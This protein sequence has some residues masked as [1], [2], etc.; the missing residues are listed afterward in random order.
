MLTILAGAFKRIVLVG[1][2]HDART[3]KVLA[4]RLPPD[5]MDYL[6]LTAPGTLN[7]L[8]QMAAELEERQ[9]RPADRSRERHF[10]LPLPGGRLHLQPRRSLQQDSQQGG[11]RADRAMAQSFALPQNIVQPFSFSTVV[12]AHTHQAGT[13]H[14]DFGTLCNKGGSM[15]PTKGYQSVA[16]IRS[17]RPPVIGWSVIIRQDGVTDHSESRF[18]PLL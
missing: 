18:I 15:C 13:V 8:E 1:C 11:H 7:P 10:R 5:V 6:A 3:K 4:D 2:N 17:T 14:R 16:R 12:Q 9:H